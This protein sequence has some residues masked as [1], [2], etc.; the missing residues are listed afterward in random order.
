MSVLNILL[1]DDDQNLANTLSHGIHKAMGKAVSV[2]VRFSAAE[3]LSVLGQHKYDVVISDLNM[4]GTSGLDFLNQVKQLHRDT[5]LI[6]ITAYGTET[7]EEEMRQLGT[8]YLTKPFEPR[9]LAQMIHNLSDQSSVGTSPEDIA[10][11]ST[12]ENKTI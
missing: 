5:V 10:K 1:V 11:F 6:L 2:V 9:R 3:A 7:L 12:V 8:G 4:P